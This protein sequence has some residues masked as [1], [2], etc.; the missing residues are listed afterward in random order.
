M[1]FRKVPYYRLEPIYCGLQETPRHKIQF[2]YVPSNI[3]TEKDLTDYKASLDYLYDAADMVAESNGVP[4]RRAMYT[5]LGTEACHTWLLL[6]SAV[7]TIIDMLTST[8]NLNLNR[9]NDQTN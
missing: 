1:L 4:V 7:E 2:S 8:E 3:T 5:T 6:P 9:T